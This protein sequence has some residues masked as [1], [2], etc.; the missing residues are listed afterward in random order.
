MKHKNGCGCYACEKGL[1]ALVQRERE[2]METYGWYAHIIGNPDGTLNYHTHGLE[3]YDHLDLQVVL[4]LRSQLIH[5]I[6]AGIVT[7]IQ[8][9]EKFEEDTDYEGVIKNFK[10]RFLL[11][12]E[13]SRNVLR[14][15]FPDAEGNLDRDKMTDPLYKRQY[16]RIGTSYDGHRN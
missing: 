10:I 4:P 12:V 1:G 16:H 5:E 14:L 15:I 2:L 7:R 13:N 6:I 11:A 9:G 8:D 3:G